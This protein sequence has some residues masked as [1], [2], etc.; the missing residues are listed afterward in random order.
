MKHFLTTISVVV[1]L[2]KSGYLTDRMMTSQSEIQ[3]RQWLRRFPAA[4]TDGNGTLT[5]EEARAFMASRRQGKNGQGPPT[6][7]YVDPGWSKARFPDNAVCY[8][9]PPEIQAIYREVFPKDPQP[10]FQVPQPEKALRIV[11]TGHSFMAPGYRTFPVI[12]RAAGFEQPLRTHT[13]GGMTR[14]LR[15]LDR[16]WS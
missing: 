15:L 6:E 12:C 1:L 3:L 14:V 9:T 2:E 11:G 16:L 13:G 7:F 10:V 8:M 4:D 5:A